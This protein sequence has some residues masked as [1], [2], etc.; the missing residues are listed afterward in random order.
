MKPEYRSIHISFSLTNHF[1]FKYF[2]HEIKL[3]K[4]FVTCVNDII[5]N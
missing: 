4:N 1:E 2:E 5:I 3:E